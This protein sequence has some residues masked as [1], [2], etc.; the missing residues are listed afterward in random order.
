MD[1][2]SIALDGLRGANAQF[3][4][5]AAG[6]VL[7]AAPPPSQ[8]TQGPDVVELSQAAVAMIEARTSA[9]ANVRV[10]HAADQM[11]RTTLNVLG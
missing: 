7:A 2:V 3:E 4:Q 9:Q 1:A 8:A 5:A 6:M 11:T 10:V